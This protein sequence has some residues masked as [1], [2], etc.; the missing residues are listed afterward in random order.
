LRRGLGAG[1]SGLINAHN[2]SPMI[3]ALIPWSRLLR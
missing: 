1:S 3:G 2:S